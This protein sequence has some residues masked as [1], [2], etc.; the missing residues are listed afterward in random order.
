MKKIE[1]YADGAD[2]DAMLRTWH[3]VDG[4]TTNP[5]LMKKAKV[6]DYREFAKRALSIAGTKPVSL[7]VFADDLGLMQTQALEIAGWGSNVVVKVP[8]TTSRGESTAPVLSALS[9]AHRIAVN[10]TAV[11]TLAQVETA[12]AALDPEAPSIISVFAGR[13][14]DTGRDPFQA[15]REAWLVCSSRK[16]KARV[17][18]ASP[19]QVRDYHTAAQAGADIITMSPEL[20][21]KMSLFGKSLEE[22]SLETVQQF[23]KDAEGISI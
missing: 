20:I 16:S 7:E 1:L 17:L 19:R 11:M 12:V 8:I 18:W 9:R 13:I 3:Q 21:E 23:L 2:F 6:R 10:V 5:S 4:F 14:A 15:V 22:Y